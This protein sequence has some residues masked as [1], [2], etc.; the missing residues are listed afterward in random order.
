[1][2]VIQ[3]EKLKKEREDYQIFTRNGSKDYW[4]YTICGGCYGVC[5]AR[6]RVVDGVPVAIEGVPE[7]DL[8]GQGG[9]CGK[10]VATILDYHDPNRVNYPVKRTNPKKGLLEDPKWE[11]ISWEEAFGTIAEKLKAGKEKDPRTICFTG[12]PMYDSA[13][14]LGIF[15]PCFQSGKGGAG[16]GVPSS[17]TPPEVV[18]FAGYCLSGPVH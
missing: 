13:P 14:V 10:G 18:P 2:Q 11:R 15:W 4:A 1:M 17:G 16:G 9:M 8:G 12:T 5:G 3:N 7:S 6:V